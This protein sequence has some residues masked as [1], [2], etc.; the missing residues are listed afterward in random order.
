MNKE[1]KKTLPTVTVAL[2]A[3]NEETNIGNFI[4]SVLK[5]KEENFVLEKILIISDGSTDKTAEI[6]KSFDSPKL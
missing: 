4:A 3:F 6:V 1:I 5:Q 2:S